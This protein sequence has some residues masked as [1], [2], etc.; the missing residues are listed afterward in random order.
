MGS[1][2]FSARARGRNTVWALHPTNGADTSANYVLR[3]HRDRRSR[4]KGKI[5]QRITAFC[6]RGRPGKVWCGFVYILAVGDGRRYTFGCVYLC[7]R[8]VLYGWNVC[9]VRLARFKCKW[10]SWDCLEWNRSWIHRERKSTK[11]I[12]CWYLCRQTHR[13]NVSR[14][15]HQSLRY[16]TIIIELK[17]LKL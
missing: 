10:V 2:K 7:W 3:L 17:I 8:L 12:N 4:Q 6:K 15:Y 5:L 14:L 11:L 13:I 1:S 16:F 9:T